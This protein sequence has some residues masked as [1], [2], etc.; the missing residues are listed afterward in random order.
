MILGCFVAVTGMALLCLASYGIFKLYHKV[1]N[2][3]PPLID[4]FP[5]N[6]VVKYQN[7]LKI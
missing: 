3:S 6:S 2:E 5:N 1:E 7:A 4:R